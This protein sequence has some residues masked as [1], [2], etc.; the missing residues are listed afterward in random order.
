MTEQLKK[1]REERATIVTNAR[2]KYDEIKADTPEARAAEIEREFDAMMADVGKLDAKIE[3]LQT[4][5]DAENRGRQ[6]D[7]NRPILDDVTGD[8]QEERADGD[9]AEYREVFSRVL[10]FGAAELSPE[11]RGI[12][13]RHRPTNMREMRAQAAGDNVA[14]GYTVP[15]GFA[16]NIDQA[17]STWGP[18]WDGSIVEELTTTTG[19]RIAYPTVDDTD[20]E[21]GDKAENEPATD[22]GSDDVEFG[23]KGLDAYMTSTGIVRISFELLQDSAFDIEAVLKSIFG[24]RM[25]K[26]ANRRLTIGTG[27]GQPNGIVTASGLGK[28]AAAVDALVADEVIDLF[29]SVDAGYRQSPKCRFQ[30]ND[31]TLASLRKLKDGQGNYLWQMG[32]VR[33]GAPDQLLG[34]PYSVNNAMADVAAGAKP[35]IFGD[36]SRYIV[37]KVGGFNVLTLRERYAEA[38]QVGMIGFA[39]FDGELLNNNAVKHMVMK[40]A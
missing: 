10:R 22:D 29:H 16:G 38:L 14:G 32:D 1:L 15:Q 24:E 37:R 31:K 26:R 36:H 35:I 6:A 5:S 30:F 34:K 4:L 8:D 18:M 39:R 13:A 19:N 3:R 7:G 21:A 27:N 20:N 11:E 17:I 33:V 23:G 2:S 28:T 40:A 9:S 12:L 25:G